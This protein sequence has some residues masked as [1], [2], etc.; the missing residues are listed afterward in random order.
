MKLFAKIRQVTSNGS[1]PEAQRPGHSSSTAQTERIQN[2]LSSKRQAPL[3]VESDSDSEEAPVVATRRQL[4]AVPSHFDNTIMEESEASSQPDV[5]Q[6]AIHQNAIVPRNVSTSPPKVETTSSEETAYKEMRG[7]SIPNPETLVMGQLIQWRFAAEEGS[8]MVH[9]PAVLGALGLMMTT[10]MPLLTR[11]DFFADFSVGHAI[12]ALYVFVLGIIICIIEGRFSCVRNPL[13]SRAQLRNIVVRHCNL[14]RLQWGRG[15]LYVMAGVLNM[16]HDMLYCYISGGFM[17]FLGLM[18]IMVGYRAA[19]N[20][21]TLRKSLSNEQFLWMKFL[22]H[23]VDGDGFLNSSEFASFIWDLGLEFDDLYT[24]KAFTT[25]DTDHD[26]RVSFREFMRWWSQIRVDGIHRGPS[27]V[28][29][30]GVRSH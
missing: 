14:L 27:S 24:L 23:D 9:I 16:A 13:G 21:S 7:G 20:L 5:E 4:P 28:P 3:L 19:K 2:T 26:G 25:I 10:P 6:G 30:D 29:H 15:L 11:D 22:K 1:A 8:L 12:V 17:V 18:A